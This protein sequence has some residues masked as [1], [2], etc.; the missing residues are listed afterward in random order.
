MNILVLNSG[1]S[2]IKYSLLNM[3]SHAS[4]LSGLI[5]RIGEAQSRHTVQSET[6]ATRISE[7]PIADHSQALAELFAALDNSSA[8]KAGALSCIGHRVVHG[9]DRFSKPTVITPDVLTR[10]EAVSA[11]APLHNPANLLGIK[12]ALHTMGNV[13]Q[14][15]VFD[16]AFHQ[17]LPDYAYRYPLPDTWYAE[18]G[19][20]RYGF[21]G[22][23]HRYVAKQA[24]KFLNAE[25]NEINL[26]TLHLGNG[27]SVTAIRNG[28]SVDTSMGMTPLEGL[29]MGSR[30]GDIDPSIPFYMARS[31][32]QPLEDFED[33]LNKSSGC[34][35][36]SGHNDMRS[37]HR[38]ADNNDASARL[39]LDM[40]A[41]RV[42]KYIGAYMAVLGR[43]DAL[44][45]T[46]G[47]GENDAW[48]RHTVCEGMQG[49]GLEL[50]SEKNA[51][52]HPACAEIS[53]PESRSKILVIKTNEELE[54]ALQA[55]E[56][57][58]H[59]F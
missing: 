16:T 43:V 14:V 30:C 27:A 53:T 7:R 57:L 9:G 38:L 36:I 39:A 55:A 11:L 51:L 49:F 19:V 3:Q 10:I 46:G 25:L 26:I 20:R 22:T 1:S 8:L 48:L 54:I 18:H 21:H 52:R 17:T 47:I 37:L 50:A 28:L 29:M 32:R 15:A 33:V 24:A 6:G 4:V 35:G 34:K 44:V 23:S 5:E 56:C 13:V 31:L 59:A 41:Y 12:E 42:K 2:S 45:F 40:F 58:E